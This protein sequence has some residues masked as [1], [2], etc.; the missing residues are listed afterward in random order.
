MH[1]EDLPG[2]TVPSLLLAPAA[3]SLILL[4][5]TFA[6]HSVR[7]AAS[8]VAGVLG[9]LLSVAFVI[10]SHGGLVW[11]GTF[12]ST[13]PALVAGTAAACSWL[14]I[15]VGAGAEPRPE[16]AALVGAGATS[17]LLISVSEWLVLVCL[18]LVTLTFAAAASMSRGRRASAAWMGIAGGT[19]LVV[20][21]LGAAWLDHELWRFPSLTGWRMWVVVGGAGSIT[22]CVPLLG[23]WASGAD[24]GSESA[25]LLL[26]AG[27]IFLLRASPGTQPWVAAGLLLMV[28]LGYSWSA[29]GDRKLGTFAPWPVTGAFALG[30]AAPGV[31]PVIGTATILALS[32][33]ILS[34]RS[35]A[36]ATLLLV[37]HLPLTAGFAALLVTGEVAFTNAT[38]AATASVAVPWSLI[39][40]ALPV[41]LI[42]ANSATASLVRRTIGG[43]IDRGAWVGA[44][45]LAA[46]SSALALIPRAVSLPSLAGRDLVLLGSA[47]FAGVMAAALVARRH[48]SVPEARAG[49][50]EATA[51]PMRF[52]V[53]TAIAALI[54][55]LGSV[56]G[57]G[58]LL[59]EGLRVGFL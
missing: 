44:W 13:G 29:S 45:V 16:R 43:R 53:A 40:F 15:A 36:G 2:W 21:G 32:V 23:A 19:A 41:A 24:P 1:L 7:S 48:R 30:L 11:R 17:L 47:L 25:P 9:V 42:A 3:L 27:F 6:G 22:G 14:L 59:V 26:G 54:F 58:Y 35:G 20:G 5:F 4:L 8:R 12:L 46:A 28:A 10:S 31:I 38:R 51:E 18:F 33:V 37:P 52:R 34:P 57:T 55:G 56:A 50:A 39:V 49:E